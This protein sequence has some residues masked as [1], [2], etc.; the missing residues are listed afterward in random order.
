MQAEWAAR[1]GALCLRLTDVET[2]DARSVRVVPT[3]ALAAE[4]GSVLPSM[5]GTVVTDAGGLWF[6]PRFPFLGSTSYT[7]LVGAPGAADQRRCTLELPSPGGAPTT[8]VREVYPTSSSLPFNHLRF[9]VEFSAPMAE[10]S[11]ARHLRIL[12]DGTGEPLDDALLS[13]DPELWDRDRRCLTVLLDPARIKRGLVPHREAGYPLAAGRAIRLEIDGAFPDAAGRPLR[14]GF[15]RRYAV[16]EAERRRV[17]P[18]SW[19]LV[20]P[21]VATRDPLV[22]ELDR[23]LDH[24]L[25]QACLCVRGGSAALDGTAALDEEQLVWAFAP[26]RPWSPGRHELV[27]SSRLEDLA[28]NSVARVFDRDLSRRADD[29]RAEAE[30]VLFFEP[31]EPAAQPTP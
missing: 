27:V 30:V 24:A 25:A 10:G 11:A 8:T 28:G 14:A 31:A 18:A 29:P 19:R 3:G 12:D 6:V 4:S 22:V 21:R 15:A 7:V 20:A 17:V 9:Y 1:E 23:P 26:R 2:L 16:G 13:M 5:A